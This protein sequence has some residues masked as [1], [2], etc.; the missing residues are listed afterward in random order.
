MRL[1][2]V[3]M[4]LHRLLCRFGVHAYFMRGDTPPVFAAKQGFCAMKLRC[5]VCNKQGYWTT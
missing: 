3:Q 5:V 2:T 4:R 1:H